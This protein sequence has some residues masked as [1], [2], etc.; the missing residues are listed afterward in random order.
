[1]LFTGFSRAS[2]GGPT[3]LDNLLRNL[4]AY[5]QLGV[6]YVLSGQADVNDWTP[7]G[8]A[9]Q[10][11]G[12]SPGP[13]PANSHAAFTLPLPDQGVVN[14]V[15]I[16]MGTYGG[17]SDGQLAV[18]L[19]VAD[20]CA[21]GSVVLDHPADNAYIPIPLDSDLPVSGGQAR[22]DL[23]R[24]GGTQ[25][26][27]LWM[28]PALPD[29]TRTLALDGGFAFDGLAPKVSL[30]LKA[31][32]P[33]RPVFRDRVMTV[34]EL[35]NPTPYFTAQGCTLDVQSREALVADCPAAVPL[36]RLELAMAGWSATVNDALQ[37]VTADGPLFQRVDLPAGRSVVTFRFQPPFMP[38]GYALFL[39]GLAALAA[40]LWRGWRAK[41][42]A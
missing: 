37:P 2:A 24:T 29:G 4:D 5:R 7:P 34:Y 9:A 31:E 14:Q 32:G 21:Q 27:V 19:C 6:K 41:A 39:V 23:Q 3:A 38:L 30:A 33:L 13:L 20:T 17:K 22:L 40:P 10:Q 11:G 35:D 28:Y 16:F 26:L 1:V 25:P 12:N 18:K 42:H 8:S 15:G 36:R